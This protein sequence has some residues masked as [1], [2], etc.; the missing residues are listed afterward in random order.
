MANT[1]IINMEDVVTCS[2]CV[3]FDAQRYDPLFGSCRADGRDA[4]LL[5][6]T[7][8]FVCV[9]KGRWTFHDSNKEEIY[10]LQYLPMLKAIIQAKSKNEVN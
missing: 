8:T 5:I 7:K 10:F 2:G 1:K 9:D 4:P 3:Y 6:V